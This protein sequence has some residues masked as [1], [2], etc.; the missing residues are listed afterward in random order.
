MADIA[1]RSARDEDL[2]GILSTLEAALGETPLLRRSPALWE[3]KHSS[4]PFGPSIILIATSGQRVAG[5][6][7]MMRWQL[8]TRSGQVI[9]ALRPVDTATHPDFTRRGIFRS[10]TMT[11]VDIAREEGVHLIF[12]TPNQK[13]A[14]GYLQMGW[15]EVSGIGVM[16]RPR[17]GPT[18]APTS[19]L[20]PSIDELAPGIQPLQASVGVTDR[21]PLG[22]RT[23]RSSRY[24]EWRFTMHPTASYGWIPDRVRGG[25]VARANVRA[26]RGELVVS[27]L[28][29]SPSPGV[30][31][32]AAG[33]SRT[34]YLAGWF[35]PGS[36]ERRTA[37]AGGMVPV[38]WL[39]TLKLVALPLGELEVDP[40]D[41]REWDLA[42]SDLELL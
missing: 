18:V 37:I 23:P 14:P 33:H 19:G 24:L 15:R 11:A 30:V 12:N 13:S 26:G 10:L 20:P 21:T 17:L 2:P 35:T 28:I 36:P 42:T 1:I 16:V 3:W 9:K 40:S 39:Q 5:V 8:R 6:R 34:R 38:P 25:L 7:A 29:G 22:L 32:R 27:D 4:N 31:R 41:L